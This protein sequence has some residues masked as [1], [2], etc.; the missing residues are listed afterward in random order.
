MSKTIASQL[1][2][3]ELVALVG[4]GFAMFRASAI[5][6]G[7]SGVLTGPVNGAIHLARAGREVQAT[8]AAIYQ[9][10]AATT[11]QGNQLARE[12]RRKAETRFDKEIASARA[13]LARRASAID[14]VARRF[15]VAVSKGCAATLSAANS[16]DPQD[17]VK[18]LVT[19]EQECEPALD[20]LVQTQNSLTE[21]VGA[22]AVNT[23]RP[24]AATVQ[25][26]I[27][28]TT[29]SILSGFVIIVLGAEQELFEGVH[30]KFAKAQL[31]PAAKRATAAQEIE[32]K[33]IGREQWMEAS[34]RFADLTY[35]QTAEYVECTEPLTKAEYALAMRD[36]EI[37]AGAAIRIVKMAAIPAVIAYIAKGPLIGAEK[38]KDYGENY[39]KA[40]E[41][42]MAL[43][44][45][46]EKATLRVSPPD[47]LALNGID[48]A[49]LLASAGF[50]KLKRKPCQTIFV[51]IVGGEKEMRARLNSKWRNKLRQGE[52]AGL[53][54]ARRDDSEAYAI[55]DRLLIR[56][57]E[58]KGFEAARSVKFYRAVRDRAEKDTTFLVYLVNQGDE[59][60]S[61]HLVDFAGKTAISVLAA[62]SDPGRDL[63][64]SFV[65][66]WALIKDCIAHGFE[67]YDTGGIDPE[68]NPGVYTFKSGMGGFEYTCSGVFEKKANSL[69]ATLLPIAESAYRRLNYLKNKTSKRPARS[70]PRNSR[71]R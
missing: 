61:A 40:V 23:S 60:I 6:A 46:K 7:L 19:M 43:Y 44:V 35:E 22:E 63:K 51:P 16:T 8:I 27:L 18:A 68:G 38:K 70:G 62:T 53:T 58:K 11:D 41:A 55:L 71:R 54:I 3:L 66:Q 50:V 12:S 30:R 14:A 57:Q 26:T 28:W 37:V 64:A 25:A 32:I 59:P 10:I 52:R 69:S 20:Q 48:A 39:K 34:K 21:N 15:H 56:A 5:N 33:L 2:A 47:L 24:I 1:F 45:E 49:A 67:F 36:G 29:F 31:A 13:A 9:N 65:A 4:L 42:L 17:A